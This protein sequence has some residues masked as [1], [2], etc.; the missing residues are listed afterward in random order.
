MT[1]LTPE[2]ILRLGTALWASKTFLSAVELGVFTAL[3]Q[4]PAGLPTLERKLGLSPRSSRD[5]LDALT[6]LKM[7]GRRDGL[8]FNSPEA[9]KFLD[10][11][12]PGYMGGLLEMLSVRLFGFWASLTE[13]L[14]TGKNQNE[15][16]TGGDFFAQLYSDPQR[17]RGF[18][19]AMTGISGPAAGAIAAKF[20]CPGTKL[21]WMLVP[22]RALF[23]S[24]CANRTLTSRE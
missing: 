14:N 20:D 23:L 24:L 13:A 12:K 18:L 7:L 10:G 9:N 8:Y 4:G 5:F 21:S 16:K 1:G 2:N 6:A 19:A 3:A 22:H 11:A 15:G 17:L